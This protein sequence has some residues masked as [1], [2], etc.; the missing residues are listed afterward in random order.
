[1]DKEVLFHMERVRGQ[2]LEA[3]QATGVDAERAPMAPG[4]ATVVRNLRSRSSVAGARRIHDPF[5]HYHIPEP[6]LRASR[7][8]LDRRQPMYRTGY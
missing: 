4:R 1:M 5:F 7:G 8:L 6:V 3:G 2:D